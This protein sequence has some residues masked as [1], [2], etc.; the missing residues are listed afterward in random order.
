MKHAWIFCW[1][2]FSL[3]GAAQVGGNSSFSGLSAS[4]GGQVAGLGGSAYAHPS[5]VN[6]SCINP[7]LLDLSESGE[8]AMTYWSIPTALKRGNFTL[9]TGEWLKDR[10]GWKFGVAVDYW[11]TGTLTMRDAAGYE[12]GEF[13]ASEMTPRV[14]ASYGSGPWSFGSSVKWS[15][16]IYAGYTAQALAADFGVIYTADS[17]RLQ[18]A[19]VLRNLGY[20]IE[21]FDETFEPVPTEWS[22]SVSQRLHHAPF[23]VNLTYKYLATPNLTYYDPLQIIRDPLTGAIGYDDFSLL[24]QAV[25]H[26]HPSLEAYLGRRLR[27]QLGFDF[28]Q[29]WENRI[30][31]WR[32]NAG[33]SYGLTLNAGRMQFQYA[34]QVVHLAG[35][36]NQMSLIRKI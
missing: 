11:N 26:F 5:G 9:G 25:R 19:M 34:Y 1:L 36:I 3:N 33:L 23:R 12:I 32:T 35:R 8:I 10:P 22:V 17:G 4:A 15:Q 6:G 31:D 24:N 18:V 27:L 2:L 7:A 14:T 21:A 16:L 30:P 20:G 29:Q 13:E 28:Q